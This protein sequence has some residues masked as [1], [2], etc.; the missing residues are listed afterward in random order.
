MNDKAGAESPHL[1]EGEKDKASEHSALD[2]LVIHEILREEGEDAI[3]RSTFGLIWSSLAAGLSMGFSLVTEA[4]MQSSLPD[5]RWRHLV[6]GIGYSVGFIL[7]ILGRQQLYTES[8]LT[9]VL[10]LL[11]RRDLKTLVGTLRLWGIVI[12]VNL[13]GTWLFAA[14]LTTPGL[15]KPDVTSAMR[16]M[17]LKTMANE[18]LPTMMKAIFAGWLIALMVWLLPS[19]RSA[20]LFVILIITYVVSIAQLSHVIAG[21]V[22]AAYGVLTGAAPLGDYFVK[23]LAPT[24]IGNTLAGVGLVALLNHAPVA[25]EIRMGSL[26]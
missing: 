24:F 21:S 12:V 25:P 11:T 8:T 5:T 4:L 15:F 9:A 6:S 14:L 22:E 17:A 26:V 18:F 10:P 7:V 23:F 20:R 3:S 13:L 1:D 2:P 19:A 16:E